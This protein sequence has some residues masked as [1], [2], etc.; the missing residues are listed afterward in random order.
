L[1][2]SAPLLDLLR[3]RYKGDEIYTF[4]GDI[5]ISINPY[6][7]I[8]GL[9]NIPTI[10]AGV[11]DDSEVIEYA[12]DHIP[13]VFTIAEKSYKM[14]MSQVVRR[15][16]RLVV[17]FCTCCSFAPQLPAVG[18]APPYTMLSFLW[19]P[20]MIRPGRTSR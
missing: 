11:L 6:K 4:T 10:T 2:A 18:V 5:L 13:H 20:R 12:R 17:D 9:Y 7:L 1:V 15:V 3:R 16:G 8:P 14:M 19:H